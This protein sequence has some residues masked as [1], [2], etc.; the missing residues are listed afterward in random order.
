MVGRQTSGIAAPIPRLLTFDRGLQTQP[1]FSPDGQSIAYSSNKA[2]NFD[3]YMQPVN[4][5]PVI[6]VTNHPAHDRQPDWSPRNDWIVFRS[7]RDGGG[8]Y[9]V[10]P[11]GG[12]EIKLTSFGEQP[13]WS[14]DGSRIL[15]MRSALLNVGHGP[16]F[17]VSPHGDGPPPEPQPLDTH[18][19]SEAEHDGS[20]GW[21]PD[22]KRIAF[23][24]GGLGGRLG[25][26]TV[27]TTR[28]TV[29]RSNIR[30]EVQQAYRDQRLAI[31]R[32]EPFAWSRDGTTIYFVG[33]SRGLSNVWSLDID[34]RT[35]AV[36]GGP[37]RITTMSEANDRIT[38][39]RSGTGIAFGVA[40]RNYRLASYRID[41]ATRKVV[42]AATWR[43]PAE[44][45]SHF[46]DLTQDGSRLAYIS[47]RPGSGSGLLEMHVSDGSLDQT[48][49]VDDRFRRGDLRGPLRWSPDGKY[50]AYRHQRL[51]RPTASA[52]PVMVTSL[53]LVDVTTGAADRQLTTPSSENPELAYGWSP[54]SDVVVATARGRRARG[55]MDILLL[56][57][58][59]APNAE[60]QARFVTGSVEYSL[61]NSSMAPN[62]K[63]ICFQPTKS[64]TSRLALVPAAGG[65]EK[66]WTWL[67]DGRYW[68]DKPRWSPDGRSIYFISTQG[69]IG[70]V[71]T[72]PFD[73]D[74]GRPV[75]EPYQVTAFDGSAEYI[76]ADAGA[77]ELAI[78][79]QRL[80]VPVVNP[81][82]GVW[83]LENSI[84]R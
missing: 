26:S 59:G 39:S 19:L 66:D 69:G 83:M 24:T 81:T 60:R 77:V 74:R 1:T 15:F 10:P 36:V 20:V 21:H 43:T 73:P 52:D 67:T 42:G 40:N 32:S 61:W 2:G 3:I 23:L 64:G 38:V 71:W 28:G 76:P 49:A 35:L 9:L 53:E 5:G 11:L 22:S 8:L 44:L 17:L 72:I 48:L 50:I 46:P 27:D 58:A 30:P 29:E 33:F 70:Q 75:G 41:T 13:R 55:Q 6:Q 51:E 82:G 79:G 18:G 12:R 4:E 25:M 56:P 68:A 16:V 7:D 14:P 78:G 84:R 57:I 31:L 45:S 47:F 62:G 54:K 65:T 34:S 80:V 63:W 37:H